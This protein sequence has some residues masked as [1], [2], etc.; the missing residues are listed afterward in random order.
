MRARDIF[1]DRGRV[2]DRVRVRVRDKV[3][4]SDVDRAPGKSRG[5]DREKV[6]VGVQG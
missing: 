5:N 1:R 2:R 4:G 3:G 6:R